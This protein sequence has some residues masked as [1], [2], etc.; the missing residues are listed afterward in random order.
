MMLLLASNALFYDRD[1]EAR[2]RGYE[3]NSEIR[4]LL[5]TQEVHLKEPDIGTG[6][7]VE[8]FIAG[9]PALGEQG[10]RVLDA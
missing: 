8:M 6:N 9:V 10:V 4:D 7:V 1:G 3:L 5:V 2:I